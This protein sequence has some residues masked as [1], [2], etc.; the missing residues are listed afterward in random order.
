MFLSFNIEEV[1]LTQAIQELSYSDDSPVRIDFVSPSC[2][3][4]YVI[5]SC[6]EGNAISNVPSAR[7]DT[8]SLQS[9]SK[10]EEILGWRPYLLDDCIVAPGQYKMSSDLD[11]W[12]YSFIPSSA[13]T[14]DKAV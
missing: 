6:K 3:N 10:S 2:S 14:A 1:I 5:S 12:W 7:L 13:I 11:A 8:L 9:V 4:L